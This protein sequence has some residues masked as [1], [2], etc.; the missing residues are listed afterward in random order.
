MI[1]HT[2]IS[3]LYNNEI[4]QGI[5]LRREVM[6]LPGHATILGLLGLLDT[7]YPLPQFLFNVGK[8]NATL[9]FRLH[10]INDQ[11]DPIMKLSSI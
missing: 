7:Q 4:I 11:S 2:I 10:N 3:K 5:R 9:T 1:L 8:F 6:R